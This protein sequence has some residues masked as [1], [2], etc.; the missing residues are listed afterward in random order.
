MI[1]QC[2]LWP[3]MIALVVA[4]EV[5]RAIVLLSPSRPSSHFIVEEQLGRRRRGV[6]MRNVR[7]GTNANGCT[8]VSLPRECR[9]STLTV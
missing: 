5:C 9:S 6:D 8:L 7:S 4:P 3:K 1:N 2:H